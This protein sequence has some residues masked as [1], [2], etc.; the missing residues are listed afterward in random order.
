MDLHDS[1][2]MTNVP[3]FPEAL[4]SLHLDGISYITSTVCGKHRDMATFSLRHF[5]AKY[6]ILKV[7]F[8]DVCPI[9]L[10]LLIAA[11]QQ[12]EG[13]EIHM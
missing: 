12:A 9:I 10:C 2:T 7:P 4:L 5:R 11:V 13:G 6:L 1:T 3:S 8:E